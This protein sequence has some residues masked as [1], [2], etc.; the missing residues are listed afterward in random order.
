MRC[1]RKTR[2][3]AGFTMVELLV[4]M[5]LLAIVMMGLAALQIASIRNVS[6]ARRSSEAMRLAQSVVEELKVRSMTSEPWLSHTAAW[7][8]LTDRNNVEMSG[9]ASDGISR[10]P[11]TVRV[12]VE[13]SPSGT[14]ICLLTVK[15][16]WLDVSAAKSGATYDYEE[17][18]VMLTTMRFP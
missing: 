16:T 3:D 5:L 14:N 13:E 4:T 17:F 11:Y 6:G 12:L 8:T 15:V 2:V 10:G 1:L 7:V 18:N 9:V